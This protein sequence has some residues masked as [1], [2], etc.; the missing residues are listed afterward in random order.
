MMRRSMGTPSVGFV[1]GH[2]ELTN[3]GL[4]AIYAKNG[5]LL[6]I[7]TNSLAVRLRAC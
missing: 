2:M 1:G 5:E 4:A 6:A 3:S 7:G